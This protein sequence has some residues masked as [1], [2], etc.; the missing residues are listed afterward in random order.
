MQQSLDSL[1]SETDLLNPSLTMAERVGAQVEGWIQVWRNWSPLKEVGVS[2][3]LWNRIGLAEMV[4]AAQPEPGSAVP[5]YRHNKI[6]VD[7][8]FLHGIHKELLLRCVPSDPRGIIN[9]VGIE[10]NQQN[11][12]VLPG[13]NSRKKSARDNSL[14][15]TRV[16]FKL[17]GSYPGNP[18]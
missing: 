7:S 11:D 9:L 6:D 13:E 16:R 1:S 8:V 5:M 12:T 17:V 3:M 10:S 2:E 15:F 4:D 14:T 18:G